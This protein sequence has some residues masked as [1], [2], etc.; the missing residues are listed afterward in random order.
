MVDIVRDLTN[1]TSAMTTSVKRKI[2]IAVIAN[3]FSQ[4]SVICYLD[5]HFVMIIICPECSIFVADGAVTFVELRGFWNLDLD[6]PTVAFG[7]KRGGFPCRGSVGLL[8]G[9]FGCHV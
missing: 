3:I 8:G 2:T 9:L 7:K 6:T 5:R 1:H 4:G